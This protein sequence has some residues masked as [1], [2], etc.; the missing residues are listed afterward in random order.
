[1]EPF[2]ISGLLL[3]RAVLGTLL[4][5]GGPMSPAEVAAALDAAGATTSPE[6][7][8]GPSRLIAD[9]LAYQVRIGKVVKVGPALF[10]AVPDRISRSTRQR[11]V[12]WRR[13]FDQRVADDEAW[14]AEHPEDSRAP[15]DSEDATAGRPRAKPPVCPGPRL[16]DAHEHARDAS[17][18][19][20]LGETSDGRHPVD[21]YPAPM[22]SVEAATADD[23]DV[24]VEQ[25]AALFREDAGTYDTFIDFTWSQRE[26]RADFE[27]LIGSDDCLV[28]VAR[29]GTTI[30]AHL[31][32][33]THAASSTR[34][35]VTYAN[36]RSLYVAPTH[37]RRGAADQLTTAFVEWARAKGCV[38][39]HVDSYARNEPAQ[40]LYERH[41]FVVRSTASALPL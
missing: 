20:G 25:G 29:E 40:R 15:E 14:M 17:E 10:A 13:Q 12:G 1:M 6:R 16:S 34:L 21:G 8:K 7:T 32:G 23:L 28:L 9:L 4:S 31:V 37:R 30:I 2:P 19:G 41:G 36:L 26:G 11:C 22:F 39:A 35:P 27:R 38:E 3:R 18:R 33:Y 5:A 24:L